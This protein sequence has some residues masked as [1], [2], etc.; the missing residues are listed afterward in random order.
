MSGEG[1]GV[2]Q[3]RRRARQAMAWCTRAGLCALLLGCYADLDWREVAP[4]GS[5][6][7]AMLP[8]RVTQETRELGATSPG[9]IM[10]Q[11]SAS[12]RDSLFAAGYADLPGADLAAG[13]AL[14]DGLVRNISGRIERE[15]DIVLGDAKGRETIATGATS[16]RNVTL[17]LRQ[18]LQ[19]ARLYQVIILGRPGD[20]SEDELETFFGSFRLR[21]A[22]GDRPY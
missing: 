1:W 2:A 8:S 20:L 12:A 21:E 3:R 16:G 7:S 18:Y 14:R 4:P 6:F 22:A 19:G 15:R 13:S 9:M 5:G 17:H 11:W 10:H